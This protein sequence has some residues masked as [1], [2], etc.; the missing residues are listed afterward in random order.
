MTNWIP[1]TE[2][3]PNEGD[4]VL[5]YTSDGWGGIEPDL[6]EYALEQWRGEE[7]GLQAYYWA[8]ITHWML[9]PEPPDIP[10]YTNGPQP[11]ADMD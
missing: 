7:Y 11:S 6:T 2:R 9:A 8:S 1:V 5:T 10:A 4:S 3:L